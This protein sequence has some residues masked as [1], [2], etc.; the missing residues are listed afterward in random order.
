MI[1]N[2][3]K[4]NWNKILL[5]NV[6]WYFASTKFSIRKK[7]VLKSVQMC[8]YWCCTRTREQNLVKTFCKAIWNFLSILRDSVMRKIIDKNIKEVNIWKDS[9]SLGNTHSL[10]SFC[11]CGSCFLLSA[12]V[13]IN[14]LTL[15][16]IFSQSGFVAF[17]GFFLWTQSAYLYHSPGDFFVAYAAMHTKTLIPAFVWTIQIHCKTISNRIF[18]FS[19]SLPHWNGFCLQMDWTTIINKINRIFLK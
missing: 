13:V 8:E 12:F 15:Y 17:I 11:C 7:R 1:C 3:S 16:Y 10:L 14:V 18:S 2:K 5:F 9:N 4:R 6:I 19:F